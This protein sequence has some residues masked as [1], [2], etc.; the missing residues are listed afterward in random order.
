MLA[1]RLKEV[2]T[3]SVTAASL[4]A[5][6]KTLAVWHRCLNTGD[7]SFLTLCSQYAHVVEP[8]ASN[9]LGLLYGAYLREMLACFWK[10]KHAYHREDEFEG[11]KIDELP[12]AEVAE[13]AKCLLAQMHRLLE[14]GEARVDLG[15][16]R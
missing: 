6:M 8:P 15:F 1:R 10:C 14:C 7:N 2:G 3:S 13:A 5:G 12:A 4:A 16:V 9:P 11:S